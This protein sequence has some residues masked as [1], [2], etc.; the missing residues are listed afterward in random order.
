MTKI[1]HIQISQDIKSKPVTQLY[2][3]LEQLLPVKFLFGE[4]DGIEVEGAIVMDKDVNIYEISIPNLSLLLA[5]DLENESEQKK[6]EV[7]FAD[8]T[9]VPF[10]FRGRRVSTK[11]TQVGSFLTVRNNEKILASTEQGVI[12]LVSE[13]GITKY[14][15][16]ALSL[17]HISTEQ[18]FNDVFNGDCFL[19]MLVLLHFISVISLNIKY[20]P[21]PLRASFII[22]DPNLHWPKY[23]FVDYREIVARAK[24]QNYHVSFA[25]IPLDTWFTH[26]VT[27]ELFRTN[28]RWISLLIHGN[29]HAKEELAQNYSDAMLKGLL[30]QA[31]QRI[32]RME[33]KA[34]ISVCRV[35]VPPHGACTDEILAELSNSGFESAC[36]SAGSLRFHNQDK[37]WVK[38]LGFFPAEKIHGFPVL[39]RWGLTG[40]VKNT[41]LIAAYL[42]QPMILRGHHQDLKD[43]GDM[44]DEYA[45]FI[46]GLGDVFWSNMTDL[47]RLNYLW[48]EEGTICRIKVLGNKILFQLPIE[49]IAV[50]IETPFTID[51]VNWNVVT[52]NGYVYK[53]IPGELF[54]LCDEMGHLILIE[55]NDVCQP[56]SQKG[57]FKPTPKKLIFR[58]LLTETRDRLYWS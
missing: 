53:I 58:R 26:T 13:I 29:N 21:A 34:N 22:D 39:P 25:T 51:V 46:N 40:N 10:P 38:T 49:A 3:I 48:R 47:S 27:A 43:G 9:D 30:Q 6:T 24:K 42:G 16:S 44:F 20:Q 56:I 4:Q 55:R 50:I 18:N 41:L 23:G 17:P 14:F 8:D 52:T 28:S 5:A 35:M 7:E 33:Q 36:I 1:Y 45:S 19:E 54:L 57:V 15:R 37:L 11:L 32:K 2:S 12:W 31:I